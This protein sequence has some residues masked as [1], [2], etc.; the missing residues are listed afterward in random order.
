MVRTP[1]HE[2]TEPTCRSR[3][4]PAYD[5]DEKTLAGLSKSLRRITD[6][7]GHTAKVFIRR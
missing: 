1:D 7:N 6:T 3:R 5:D 4:T 2:G